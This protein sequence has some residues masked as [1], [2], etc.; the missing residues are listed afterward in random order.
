MIGTLE[1]MLWLAA[2]SIVGRR[3][4]CDDRVVAPDADMSR[5]RSNSSAT[6]ARI[7]PVAMRCLGHSGMA[8]SVIG[9]GAIWPIILATIHGFARLNRALRSKRRCMMPACGDLQDRIASAS[10]ELMA[11]MPF[12]LTWRYPLRGLR[13]PAGLEG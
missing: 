10:P 4:W 8:C 11:G 7:I 6:A 12:S 2:A 1:H 5:H 3:Y 13:D 9:F